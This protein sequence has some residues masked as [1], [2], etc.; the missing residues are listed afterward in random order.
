MKKQFALKHFNLC[1]ISQSPRRVVKF[2][3]VYSTK[4]ETLHSK[5][6]NLSLCSLGMK[7][8]SFSALTIVPKGHQVYLFSASIIP[9]CFKV[10]S[11]IEFFDD[12]HLLIY[13]YVR[14]M[15]N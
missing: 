6:S 9:L 13:L 5:A 14:H 15:P 2:G 8:F 4:K 10:S 11:S 3:V 1:I 7:F 12:H